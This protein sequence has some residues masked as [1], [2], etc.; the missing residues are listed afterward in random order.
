[1]LAPS[2]APVFRS[3]PRRAGP[4]AHRHDR[5]RGPGGHHPAGMSDAQARGMARADDILR[6]G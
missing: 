2:A 3:S 1:M 4:A 5:A 6:S